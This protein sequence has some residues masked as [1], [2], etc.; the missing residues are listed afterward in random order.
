MAASLDALADVS[1]RACWSVSSATVGHGVAGMLGLAGAGAFWQS[2]G[3]KP[4]MVAAVFG[5]A[6]RVAALCI[7]LSPPLDESYTPSAVRVRT[8][9]TALTTR[10]VLRCTVDLSRLSAE[11][12]CTLRLP[13]SR[14][15]P[16]RAAPV[17]VVQVEIEECLGG[18]KD[19]RLRGVRVLAEA[20]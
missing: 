19:A 10:D 14:E 12:W 15:E 18:G 2:D 8:G 11:G 3:E 17:R 20:L 6:E 1:D 16:G 5:R 4:H 7:R 13:G 9:Q